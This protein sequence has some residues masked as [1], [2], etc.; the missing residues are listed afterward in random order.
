MKGCKVAKSWH[1]TATPTSTLGISSTDRLMLSFIQ[2]AQ[3]I[4]CHGQD[5]R[6]LGIGLGTHL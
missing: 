3:G 4:F 6:N 1:Q 2:P 5:A